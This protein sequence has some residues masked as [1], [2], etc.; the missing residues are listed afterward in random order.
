MSYYTTPHWRVLRL[1]A[2]RR[3]NWTCQKC[4]AVV[5]GKK[6]GGLSPVVD[7][8]QPRPRGDA[9]SPQDVLNNLTTLCQPCHNKKT[10]WVDYNDKPQ[11]GP[12]GLPA[13]GSWS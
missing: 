12:D 3:D 10:K 11:V 6:R 8:I 13:D 5:I 9:V 1:K 2:I 7:H 4:G